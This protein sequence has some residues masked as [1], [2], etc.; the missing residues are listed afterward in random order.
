MDVEPL[1]AEV[2]AAFEVYPSKGTSSARPVVVTANELT[3]TDGTFQSIMSM[4]VSPTSALLRMTVG[5]AKAAPN[6]KS[7]A[8]PVRTPA[9]VA[10]AI[11]PG[12]LAALRMV[13]MTVGFV[14]YMDQ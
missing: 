13:P 6:V 1:V 4:K 5:L 8:V 12:E 3:S 10:G 14:V 7:V 11:G 2:T 9:T